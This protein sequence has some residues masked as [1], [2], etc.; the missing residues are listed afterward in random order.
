MSND[1]IVGTDLRSRAVLRVKKKHEFRRHLFVYLVVNAALVTIWAFTG[2]GFFWPMFPLLFW[3][4]GV[5][6][7][8]QDAYGRNDISEEEIRQEIMRMR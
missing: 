3:G 6:F 2:A 5:I 1:E 4:M 8:A 7:H